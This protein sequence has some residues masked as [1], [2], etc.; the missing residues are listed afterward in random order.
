MFLFGDPSRIDTDLDCRS[1][2]FENPTGARGAGGTAAGGR[3]GA[4]NRRIAT[5]ETVV[6]ADIAGPGRVRH[7]WMTFMAAPPEEMRAVTLQV[8]YDE[9]AEPSISVPCLDFFGLPHGRMV[10]CVTAMTAVQEGRGLNSYFPMPFAKNIRIELTNA[11]TRAITLYYQV[12]YTLER[13]AD[14]AGY[15]HVSFRRENPTTLKRDFTIAEGFKGPGRFLGCVVGVRVLPDEMIWY[16]EGEFKF[17]RDGDADLPTICGTGLEDYVGTAWGMGAHTAPAQG[18]PLVVA[19]PADPGSPIPPKP[20]FVGFYRWHLADPMVFQREMRATIQQIGALMVPKG[21]EHLIEE[22]GAR[23]VLAGNGWIT[24]G[25][26][27]G[28]ALHGFAI[29]E[30]VDDYSAAAFIYAREPQ[31]VTRLDVKAAVADIGRRAY[32]KKP[33]GIVPGG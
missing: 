23:Y 3:K 27:S 7:I 6:L 5:G 29:A 17:F 26:L 22:W 18:A 28:S 8:F 10:H 12:D 21:A 25:D 24:G 31:S 33:R 1:I 9:R 2:S 20:D 13:F 11:G 19:P 14:D 4:P 16:G 32:E 30:R 15:L